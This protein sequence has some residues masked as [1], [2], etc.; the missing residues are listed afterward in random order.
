MGQD[1]AMEFK[2]P[3]GWYDIPANRRAML[4]GDA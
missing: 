4:G 3:Y 1:N 2:P